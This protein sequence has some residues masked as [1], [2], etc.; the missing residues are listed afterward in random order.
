MKLIRI[1]FIALCA[2]F[3]LVYGSSFAL[4]E[5]PAG[6]GKPESAAMQ[7]GKVNINQSSAEEMAEM[8]QGIGPIRA[9]MIVEY[10]D[11]NGPFTSVDQLLEI[12]GIGAATLEKNR[13]RISL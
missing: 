4:A 10:R 3:V 5:E 7:V 9:E 1:P 8:L 2:V 11:K 6:K 12:Q 13:D